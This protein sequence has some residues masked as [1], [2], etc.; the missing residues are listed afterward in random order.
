MKKS[1][2]RI[3]IC[4]MAAVS[5]T[6]AFSVNALAYSAGTIYPTLSS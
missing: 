4:L 1:K 6:A 5:C 3:L 2:I